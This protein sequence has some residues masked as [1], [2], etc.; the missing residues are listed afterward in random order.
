MTLKKDKTMATRT[1]IKNAFNNMS[2]MTDG[3]WAELG[4]PMFEIATEKLIEKHG[5]ESAKLFFET[6][7]G[8]ERM[9][10]MQYIAKSY[11]YELSPK[12]IT[13]PNER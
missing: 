2:R 10:I 5:D 7:A 8:I 3:G 9:E 6:I 12:Y 11:P 13:H 1:L 4:L